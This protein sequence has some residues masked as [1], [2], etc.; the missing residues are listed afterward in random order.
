MELKSKHEIHLWFVYTLYTRREGNFTQ[1]L[2][3]YDGNPPQEVRC[4]ISHCSIRS[5]QKV[6]EFEELWIL[7]LLYYGW[8]VYI[9]E[10]MFSAK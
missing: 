7:R 2:W 4:R 10:F 6:L 5:A 8:S 1:Y 9:Y 3:C